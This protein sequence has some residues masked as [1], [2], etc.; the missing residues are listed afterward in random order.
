[1]YIDVH[2]FTS[3]YIDAAINDAIDGMHDVYGIS[4]LCIY[5]YIYDPGSGAPPSPR[6]GDGPYMYQ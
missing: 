2:R 1:M 5:I 3:I 4:Y 6:D